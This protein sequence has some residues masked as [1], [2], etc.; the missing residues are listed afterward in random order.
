MR[1]HT[2]ITILC[3]CFASISVAQNTVGVLQFD[4]DFVQEGYNLYFP[5]QQTDAF[6]IDNCG[7]IINKWA[8]TQRPGNGVYLK[9]N[10]NLV[11]TGSRGAMSNQWIHAGGGGEYVEERDWDDNLI[12]KFTYNDSLVRMHHDVAVM[13]NGNILFIAW[14]KKG[15][16]EAIAAGRDP[17]LL[18]DG[19]VWPD[20]VV[21]IQPT[22]DS[23]VVVWEWNAWDHL[24][25]DF[26]NTKANFGV[27]ADHP[28]LINLNFDDGNGEADWLH[29]NSIDYNSTLDQIVLSIPSFGELWVIDHSTTTAEAA[30]STGGNSGKGG[31]LLYRWGNPMT[32]DQGAVADQ[33]LF[34]QHDVHWVDSYGLPTTDDDYGKIMIFNNRVGADYSSVN[35]IAPPVNAAGEYTYTAGA[36]YGPATPDFTYVDNPPS[37]MYSTGLSGAQ[38]L[39]NGNILVCSGRQGRTNE[40][41]PAG[42]V[43]W[44]HINP[45]IQGV[46]FSQGDVVLP[47]TNFVWRLIRY[48]LDYPAFVGKV[49][50]PGDYIE[51]NPDPTVCNNAVANADISIEHQVEIYPNPAADLCVIEYAQGHQADIALVNILGQ[52]ILEQTVDGFPAALNLASIPTGV[53]LITVDG[54]F[55]GKLMVE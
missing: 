6:L 5:H 24:I 52:P 21:E 20:K 7:R 54:L 55:A 41:T 26:D 35:I 16:A 14:E 50:T 32:Y 53:Y 43:V 42:D 44:S 2:F 30:G 34:F 45:I 13:P 37:N 10:G 3:L 47:N 1:P 12:W 49:L 46:P 51:L 29:A 11:L 33:Q 39:P 48:P 25:Q 22:A 27:L 8:G 4:A 28:E 31:D 38:K 15:M 18:P 23:A 40:I 19:E 9:E 36:A 17:N